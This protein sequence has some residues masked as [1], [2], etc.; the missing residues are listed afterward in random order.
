MG[1]N[2]EEFL[3]AADIVK[4]LKV[5]PNDEELKELY[6]LFKQATVGDNNNDK[7]GF[8]DFQ[9]QAKHTS[10]LKYKGLSTHDA[11][12][13]YIT[14]VNELISLYGVDQS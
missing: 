2:S 8:L 9:G 3:L 11:E 12:V 4:R 14:K 7:P 13:N 6:G 5:K 1:K 10:W